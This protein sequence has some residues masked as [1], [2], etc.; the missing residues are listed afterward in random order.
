M[1][2]LSYIISRY[3][4]RK[5]KRNKSEQQKSLHILSNKKYKFLLILTS[6]DLLLCLSAIISCVDEK[7]YFQ[8]LVSH[9]HLCSFHI[10]IWKFT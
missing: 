5:L 1:L 4:Q 9:F 6:N 2:Y 10:L 7:Y 8:S 3:K